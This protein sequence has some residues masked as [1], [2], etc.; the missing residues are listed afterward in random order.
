MHGARAR[1]VRVEAETGRGLPRTVLSGMPDV[2]AREARERLPSALAAHGF[3]YPRGKVL[4]NLVPAQLPKSGLPL[5]L[6]LAAAVLVADAQWPTPRTAWLCLAELD[7]QGRLGPPARGTLLAALSAAR[8]V[9]RGRVL[10][11]ITA[12]E[13]AGEASLAPGLTVYG[14]KNLA[15]VAACFSEEDPEHHLARPPA[16]AALEVAAASRL[17]LD[18]VRGQPQAREALVIAALGAHALWL[19]GPPGTGKSMLARR[20]PG[21]LEDL[22]PQRALELAQVEALLG[23]VRGLLQRPP[24]RSPHVSATAQALLG[25]G[26]PLRPGELSRAHGGVLFLDEFPE[27]ARPVLEGLRQPLE[28]GEV[29]LQRAR[30]WARFPAAVL[31]VAASNPCPCGYLGHPRVPCRC[32]ETLLRRYQARISGPLQDR[33]DLYVEVGPVEASALDGPPAPPRDEDIHSLLARARAFQRAQ[34]AQR[35]F[36]RS[37]EAGL[38]ALQR[39]GV[40]EE[41]RALLHAAAE[42]LSLS[43]RGVLRTLRVARTIAD[44]AEK[45]RVG[46]QELRSALSYR[47]LPSLAAATTAPGLPPAL[48]ALLRNSAG[49]RAPGSRARPATPPR[50]V[51]APHRAAAPTPARDPPEEHPVPHGR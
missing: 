34:H 42:S 44:L 7:L 8:A 21:L 31:L 49:A 6:A 50:D 37:G 13:A 38:D 2:V 26:T 3:A 46:K 29:R 4:F 5:D 11:M 16:R 28:E 22:D 39:G 19:Q 12:L 33:F 10:R 20:L 43:G 14:C 15:E 48:A 41:A 9:Q 24:F 40:D 25:G 36:V 23:P 32:G 47:L 35:G 30:E 51:P 18:E 1:L 45:P 17:R 27:F